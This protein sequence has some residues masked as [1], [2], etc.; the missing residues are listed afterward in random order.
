M[1]SEVIVL[2]GGIFQREV[3]PKE[4]YRGPKQS[5]ANSHND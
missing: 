2:D 3:T 5:P 4:K 1:N